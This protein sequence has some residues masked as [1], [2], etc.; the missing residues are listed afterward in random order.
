MTDQSRDAFEAW[1]TGPIGTN[2]L[3]KKD[4]Q[5]TLMSA[6]TSWVSWQAATAAER[7]RAA[8]VWLP[9]ADAPKDGT[10]ILVYH[11]RMILE[12][13]YSTKWERFVVSET[14]G[15]NGIK[16]THW[17]PLPLPPAIRQGGDA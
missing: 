3:L 8:L 14:G 9:I 1:F 13:W 17:M 5:Y 6:Q 12:T 7:E 16:P 2:F 10:P 11:N 15:T 4:G